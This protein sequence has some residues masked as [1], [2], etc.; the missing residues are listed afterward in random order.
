MR[1]VPQHSDKLGM[2]SFPQDSNAELL[3]SSST[4][5]HQNIEAS[6]APR[7]KTFKNVLCEVMRSK[8]LCV[9]PYLLIFLPTS[10]TRG[11]VEVVLNA[12]IFSF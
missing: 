11:N 9:L 10:K 4:H 8:G 12:V 7:S 1:S 2:C 6:I 3:R 5:L